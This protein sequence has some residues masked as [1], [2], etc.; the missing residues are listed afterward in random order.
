MLSEDN[1]PLIG[2][3][4]KIMF[5]DS[6][7]KGRVSGRIIKKMPGPLR[8]DYYLLQVETPIRVVN[9]SA[10]IDLITHLIVMNYFEVETMEDV[11]ARE[12]GVRIAA[13][14]DSD[15]IQQDTLRQGQA[16]DCWRGGAILAE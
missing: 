16:R 7:P 6:Q 9:A 8:D 15:V 14:L 13:I 2:K 10:S 3:R 11:L 4:I 1:D 12:I 5:E